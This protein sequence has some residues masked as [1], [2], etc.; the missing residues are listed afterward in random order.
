MSSECVGLFF[1]LSE[2]CV[3]GPRLEEW[4]ARTCGMCAGSSQGF[5]P[6]R[7]RMAHVA[8]GPDAQR[9]GLGDV[10]LSPYT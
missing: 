9:P 10:R 5:P 6:A 8:G 2:M 3:L 7:F 1:F 4:A